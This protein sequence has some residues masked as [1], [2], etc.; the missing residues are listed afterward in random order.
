ANGTHV[1]QF[2]T[3]LRIIRNKRTSMASAFDNGTTIFGYYEGSGAVLLE[4][5]DEY[6]FSNYGTFVN[7]AWI[8]SAQSSLAA[9]IGR[10][11][12]YTANFIFDIDGNPVNGQPTVREWATEEYDFYAQDSWKIRPNL[13]LNLG[14]R[15]GLSR[16]VYETQGF[17]AAPNI[18]L[19][20]YFRRRLEY[21]ES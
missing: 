7:D 16:P 1:I 4:P 18:A 2:G 12:Q 19:D 10:I 11:N 6:L 14:L 17:Q 20:D 5:L 9:V 3:N 8:N 15:Y 13:T 21:A